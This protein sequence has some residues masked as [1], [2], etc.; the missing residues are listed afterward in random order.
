M[1]ARG[2]EVE[3]MQQL[4]EKAMTDEETDSDDSNVLVKRTLP[5]RSKKLSKLM[6]ALDNRKDSKS[7]AVPKKVRKTGSPSKRKQPK[8]LPKWASTDTDSSHTS[9]S[10]PQSRISSPTQSP[11][12]FPSQNQTSSLLQSQTFSTQNLSSTPRI[13]RRVARQVAQPFSPIRSPSGNMLQDQENTSIN[14]SQS[15]ESLA[16]ERNHADSF[17]DYD[18][19]DELPT[20]I[21]VVTNVK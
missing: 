14:S 8:Q 17:S 3:I 16:E 13:A 4:G 9:S 19:N 21:R 5:W 1:Q 18:S 20:W 11:T 12:S 15:N 10:S 6:N 2:K 7:E